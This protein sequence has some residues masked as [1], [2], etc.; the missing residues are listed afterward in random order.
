MKLARTLVIGALSAASVAVAT[1]GAIAQPAS[2]RDDIAKL[3]NGE[4]GTGENPPGSN[5]TPYGP[6]E[7]WCA[8][9]ATWAWRKAGIDI[10]NYGFTGDIYTWGKQKGRAHAT[11]TGMHTGDIVLYGTGPSSVD[12]SV[13]TGIVV[14]AS[15]GKITTV[16][17]NSGDEVSKHGPFDPQHAE[18]AGRPADIYGWVSAA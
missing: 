4:I 8:H 14:A 12:T 7:S 1:P 6:C 10:P 18:A 9:F 2:V 13:H 11:D 16:E 5:C 15:G 3:A 17:G